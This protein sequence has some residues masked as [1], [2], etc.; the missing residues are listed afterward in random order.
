MVPKLNRLFVVLFEFFRRGLCQK[1]Y[2][3]HISSII[4]EAWYKVKVVLGSFKI[5]PNSWF[6]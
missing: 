4:N 6:D 2:L 3:F 5:G 1:L